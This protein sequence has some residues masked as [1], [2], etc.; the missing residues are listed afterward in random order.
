MGADY[1]I[2]GNVVDFA[3]YSSK[4]IDDFAC[5][6]VERIGFTSLDSLIECINDLN[7]QIKQ[8]EELS[9]KL[10]E[11]LTKQEVE[12]AN[13]MQQFPIEGQDVTTLRELIMLKAKIIELSQSRRAEKLQCWQ[14][15]SKL[16]E[17]LR[18]NTREL[19]EKQNRM[20]MLDSILGE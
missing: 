16:K 6:V 1:C 8:R 10:L 18:Q 3:E 17:E 2:K 5:G 9:L 19:S 12:V 15:I 20:N 14:D 7:S 4:K 11:D 13:F